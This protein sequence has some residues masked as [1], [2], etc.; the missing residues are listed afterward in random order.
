MMKSCG[1]PTCG[2]VHRRPQIL[3]KMDLFE[4]APC[5][6]AHSLMIVL[7]KNVFFPTVEPVVD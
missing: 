2:S 7:L 1:T 4:G 6:T 3:V 5:D